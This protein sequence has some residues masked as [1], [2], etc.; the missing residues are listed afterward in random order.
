MRDR[1]G[2]KKDPSEGP[3]LGAHGFKLRYGWLSKAWSLFGY[4]KYSVP[5]YNR[6]PK[7]DHQLL[8]KGVL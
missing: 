2:F 1:A 5:H 7:R 8:E 6:D 4:P 3:M